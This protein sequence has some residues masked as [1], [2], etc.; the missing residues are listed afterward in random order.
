ME[1]Q[2]LQSL[3]LNRE[4][5]TAKSAQTSKVVDAQIDSLI[6][7]R[8][9]K[10]QN[11]EI[12]KQLARLYL[13]EGNVGLAID[14]LRLLWLRHPREDSITLEI[15]RL[16]AGEKD[17]HRAFDFY[18]RTLK[19]N[20]IHKIALREYGE[21][22]MERGKIGQAITI[23]E[24][25]KLAG[26]PDEKTYT[27]LSKAYR[28]TGMIT[29]SIE[30]LRNAYRLNPNSSQMRIELAEVY[31]KEELFPQARQVL[32]GFQAKGDYAR[33]KLLVEVDCLIGESKYDQATQLLQE[34]LNEY[35]EDAYIFR[36]LIYLNQRLGLSEEV[37]RYYKKLFEVE[38]NYTVYS[39]WADFYASQEQYPFLEKHLRK[40]FDYFPKESDLHYRLA[41]LYQEDKASQ[42]LKHIEAALDLSTEVKENWKTLK[43]EVLISL[44]KHAL[45]LQWFRKLDQEYP[46][47]NYQDYVQNL[48]DKDKRY[49]SSYKLYKKAAV[50]LEKG[51]TRLALKDFRELVKQIPDNLDWNEKWA[52][53]AAL[54]N[55]YPEAREGFEKCIA[56]SSKDV[57]TRYQR[58]LLHLSYLFNDFEKSLE[59]AEALF[60][61]DVTDES[62]QLQTI[63]IERHLLAQRTLSLPYF[64]ERLLE[65]EAQS[66]SSD[67]GRLKA[68]FA[69]LFLGSH[70]LDSDQW[71]YRARELFHT[72]LKKKSV[73]NYHPLAC[74]GLYLVNLM[75]FGHKD[76]IDILER[77]VKCDGRAF[78]R[79]LYLKELFRL[80]EH[81]LGVERAREF[82]EIDESDLKIRFLLQEH[83]SGEWKARKADPLHRK[84]YLQYLQSKVQDSNKGLALFDLGVALEQFASSQVSKDLYL[85]VSQTMQKARRE[86]GELDGKLHQYL[87]NVIDLGSELSAREAKGAYSKKRAYLDREISNSGESEDLALCMAN[88][89]LRHNQ[90]LELV[91]W[92]SLRAM[93]QNPSLEEGN[94]LLADY[95]FERKDLKR[96]YQYYLKALENPLGVSDFQRV[97]SRMEKIL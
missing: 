15:A 35:R 3:E 92:H 6:L 1:H 39:E 77:W 97:L 50:L 33:R 74:E 70:L 52:S 9:L 24:R 43:G 51:D 38:S 85:K 71:A 59:L 93:V 11:K 90:D 31:A 41:S 49:R 58:Q 20:P 78:V 40:G 4:S 22:L 45:A 8:S 18:E 27:L 30:N 54:E 94:M 53:L 56:Q 68:A 19:I 73:L 28:S 5:K 88:V 60:Q 55:M 65:Y 69:Y 14:E 66:K 26:S 75:D 64:E 12:G 2:E 57:Q 13:A 48:I 95:Y 21:L 46:G 62:V 61:K 80:E 25:S 42:A 81:S 23:L 79:H 86:S 82:L 10:P 76:L 47:R 7:K 63:R 84:Q 16:Y 37:H 91:Q 89:C 96:A 83:A 32:Q 87:L 36:K 72:L 17:V 29:R 44:G 34:Y 67:F